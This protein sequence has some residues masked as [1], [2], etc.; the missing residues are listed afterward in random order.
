M[1]HTQ[2]LNPEETTMEVVLDGTT[3]YITKG[4]DLWVSPDNNITANEV[5]VWM[6][7]GNQPLP[8]YNPSLEA[9]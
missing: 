8:Y 9:S 3:S 6:E 1:I 5:M 7:E 4:G 2:Y